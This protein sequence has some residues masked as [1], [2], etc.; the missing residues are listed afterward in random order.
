MSADLEFID[1]AP[2]L[3]PSPSP[4]SYLS[5]TP[6]PPPIE[7]I[8]ETPAP[9]AAIVPPVIVTLDDEQLVQVGTPE[10]EMVPITS[11]R[12]RGQLRKKPHFNYRRES[13][14]L[15]YHDLDE[16]PTMEAIRAEF[17]KHRYWFRELVGCFKRH[18]ATRDANGQV[19]AEGRWHMHI[20]GHQCLNSMGNASNIKNLLASDITLWGRVCHANIQ[21][22]RNHTDVWYINPNTYHYSNSI[23]QSS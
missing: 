11:G 17:A 15:T 21:P 23:L 9:V 3:A 19:V 6:T 18:K 16:K 13:V 22:P 10:P 20:F 1:D 4:L 2:L 5:R 14:L 8:C 7:V 12:R